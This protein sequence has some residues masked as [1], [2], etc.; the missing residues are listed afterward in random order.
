M[1]VSSGASSVSAVGLV[2]S[3]PRRSPSRT[4]KPTA[5]PTILPSSDGPSEDETPD[6]RREESRT[7]LIVETMLSPLPE[8]EEESTLEKLVDVAF[9]PSP[10]KETA[11]RSKKT[12]RA[13]NQGRRSP[14]NCLALTTASV[15][16]RFVK[17]ISLAC[18]WPN[19]TSRTTNGNSSPRSGPFSAPHFTASFT[20]SSSN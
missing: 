11:P 14:T 5:M 1:I 9:P 10:R 8:Q 15:R 3:A 2:A 16:S 7:K 13:S 12:Q 17:G 19:P 6:L 4:I 18:S 20:T